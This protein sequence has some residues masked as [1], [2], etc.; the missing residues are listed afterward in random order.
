MVV[1]FN[2]NENSFRCLI[3]FRRKNIKFEYYKI[4]LR[5]VTNTIVINVTK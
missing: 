3:I 5:I 4:L 2:F 1:K